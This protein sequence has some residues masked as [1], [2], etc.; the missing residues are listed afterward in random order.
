MSS[1]LI[2]LREYH[3]AREH[4]AELLS[5]PGLPRDLQA[6]AADALATA[7]LELVMADPGRPEATEL[8]SEAERCCERAARRGRSLSVQ[9][10][11]SF[12]ATRGCILIEQGKTEDGAAVLRDVL[13]GLEDRVVWAYCL[14]YLAVAA[15][16]KR[17]RAEG[18]KYLEMARDLDPECVV[19]QRA[20]QEIEL[21]DRP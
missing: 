12:E 13:D 10:R 15:A 19:L 17:Q 16:R 4:L 3:R 14:G 7:L 6:H 11:L 2:R 9:E 20:A 21:A 5:R 8:L 1:A 18:R